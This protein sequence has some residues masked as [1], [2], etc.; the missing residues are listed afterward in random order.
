LKLFKIKLETF[1]LRRDCY[2]LP[3]NHSESVRH[4]TETIN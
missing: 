1:F 3:T 2:S 4:D